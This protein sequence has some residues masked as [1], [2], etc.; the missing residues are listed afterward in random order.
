MKYKTINELN[1]FLFEEA[2][3][4]EAGVTPGS[5]YLILDNVT[6]LPENSRNRDIRQMRANQ[7]HFTIC[8]GSLLSLVEEGYRVYDANGTLRQ[9]VADRVLTPQE[10]MEGLRALCDCTVYSIEEIPASNE[11]AETTETN[12]KETE[13]RET[14][15]NYRIYKISIDSEDHTF[16][17]TIGGRD[18]LQ[19]WDRFLNKD[20]DF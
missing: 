3:I 16:L 6:I 10:Y 11:T 17:L 15:E 9:Q 1:H 4:A 8:D 2:H 5:F 14:E 13:K 18:N 19:E 7:L 12:E 20:I